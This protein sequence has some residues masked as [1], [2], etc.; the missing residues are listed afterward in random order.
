MKNF[1]AK[2]FSLICAFAASALLL[3]GGC[4]DDDTEPAIG[5]K[6]GSSQ[7]FVASEAGTR[8]IQVRANSPWQVRLTPDTKTWV[9]IDGADNGEMNGS[10]TVNYRTNNSLPR[11]GTLLVSSGTQQVIDT[12]YLMQYGTTPLLQFTR[13]SKQYSAVGCLDSIALDTNI[14]LSKKIYWA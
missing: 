2:R 13:E 6:G 1:S 3:G 11:K 7:V 4:S 8:T 12:V 10:F 5:S 14:P 9:T